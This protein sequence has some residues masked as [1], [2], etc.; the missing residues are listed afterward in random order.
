MHRRIQS[1]LLT[2]PSQHR[3]RGR[4]RRPQYHHRASLAPEWLSQSHCHYEP[5]PHL[6]LSLP[7]VHRDEHGDTR[8]RLPRSAGD[9]LHI[10]PLR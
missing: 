5:M 9:V 2:S 8:L 1:A 10:P 3:A 7:T 6:W 4:Y